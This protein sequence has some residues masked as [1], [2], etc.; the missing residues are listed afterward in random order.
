MAGAI[1]TPEERAYLLGMMRR[2]INSAVHRRMN[3]LVLLDDA[4][5]AERIAEALFIDAETVREH[6][7]LYETAGIEG[8]ERLRY[9]GPEPA[10]S[11]AQLQALAIELARTLSMTAK[12]VCHFVEWT[13]GVRVYKKPKCVPAKADAAKQHLT[14]QT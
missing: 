14:R 7:R 3:V 1:L 6:R 10:L 12:A 2:Q 8:V 4:W 11:K 5:P 9:Q 13:I